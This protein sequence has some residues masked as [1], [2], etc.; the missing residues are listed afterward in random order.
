MARG[1]GGGLGLKKQALLL[2]H[3]EDALDTTAADDRGEYRQVRG[4]MQERRVGGGEVASVC[5]AL[6]G[7]EW[8]VVGWERG[9]WYVR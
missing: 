1:G 2:R 3:T 6:N 5:A 7:V 8:V 9:E 4:V